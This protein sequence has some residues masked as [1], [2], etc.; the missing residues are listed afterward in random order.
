[1][2]DKP[3]AS[4]IVRTRNRPK[5]LRECLISL[6]MQSVS[7]QASEIGRGRKKLL[8]VVLVNDGGELIDLGDFDAPRGMEIH[9]AHSGFPKGRSKC[10]NIGLEL[11]TGDFIGF[12]D[13]DDILYPNHL[14]TLVPALENTR[15]NYVYSD[16]LVA[17]QIPYSSSPSGY[18]TIDLELVYSREFSHKKLKAANFIPIHTALF[19]RRVIDEWG[20]KFD[21]NLEVL[22]DWDFWLQIA[23]FTS[24]K[25]V[26]E[27]TCE[28]RIRNDGTNT[29]GQ[30][31]HLWRWSEN[32]V[33]E[34]HGAEVNGQV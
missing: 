18:A 1:M 9:Y 10:A 6:A 29:I 24:F 27:I 34:K 7:L 13:D 11:S 25:H 26:S 31:D 4:I 22:E 2:S 28:Y 3:L 21:E 16:G 14:N 8:E 20:V 5:Y 12:L 19:K 15:E 23:N 17:T 32:Y 30:F 33:R